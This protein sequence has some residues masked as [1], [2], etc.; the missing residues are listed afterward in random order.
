MTKQ[1]TTE[2]SHTIRYEIT[3]LDKERRRKNN[4]IT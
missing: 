3:A 2:K 1:R 4:F